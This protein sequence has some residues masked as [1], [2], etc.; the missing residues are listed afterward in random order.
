MLLMCSNS[1][2]VPVLLRRQ[3]SHSPKHG[4]GCS[5]S[6]VE[7]GSIGGRVSGIVF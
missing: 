4:F 1:I 6:R 2:R 7:L 5:N 3:P